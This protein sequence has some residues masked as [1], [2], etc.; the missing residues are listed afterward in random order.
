MRTNFSRY[1]SSA[2][3]SSILVAASYGGV[4]AQSLGEVPDDRS[5]GLEEIV[6]MAQKRSESLQ[7]VPVSV[8]ALSGDMV[9]RLNAVSLKDL[10]GTVP[11]VQITNF[12][13]LP[14]NAVFSIR[15]VGV[16]GV[17]PYV[18]N[19]VSIV[20]DEVPQYFSYGAL[21]DLFDVERVEV[22]KGP[23]GTLFGANTT[24]GV[25]NVITR[26]PTGEFGGKAEVSVGNYSRIDV[27]AAMDFPIAEDLAGKVAVLH[28]SRDG[29]FT[30]V[31]NGEDMGSRNVTAL[32]G[33][34]QWAPTGDFE[35]NL[36]TEYS[37]SRNGAP[38][39][40]NGA[41]AGDTAYVAP[42]TIVP[43]SRFPMYANPC[44]SDEV[45][46]KAPKKYYSANNSTPD[47]SDM[48][49]Y[50]AT[51]TL[52]WDDTA[53]GDIT[54][55]SGYRHFK[56]NEFTDQ[57]AT[58][59]FLL[60]THR[61]TEGWHFSQ[62]IRSAFDVT[63]R[64]S[65]LVGGFYM[66]THYDHFMNLRLPFAMTGYRSL[67]TQDQDNWSASVFAQTY[68]DLSDK[69]T[70]Q[71]GG[72]YTHEKTSMLAG[73][74]TFMNMNGDS[75]FSGD[76]PLGGFTAEGSKSWDQF[77]WKIGLDH[78][79]TENLFLY[80][81]YARGFKSGGFVGELI[82]PEDI[83]PYEP[84]KVDTIEAG[85]KGDW[86]NNRLR[87][88]LAVFY[89]KYKDMQVSQNYFFEDAN[90]VQVNGS[91]I[92]NAAK[93]TLKGAELEV[94]A[95]PVEGLT[96]TGA[97]A[98]LEAEYDRFDYTAATG[99]TLDL[100]GYRLQNAPKWS[101]SLAAS[102]EF[103]LGP[104]SM[105]LHTLYAYTGSKYLSA[106]VNP[107]RVYIQPTHYLSANI[108]W[109]PDNGSWSIGLWAT[110][111]LDKRYIQS[112]VHQPGVFDN[113]GYGAPREYGAMFKYNW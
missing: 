56:L 21:L 109:T 52:N 11:N 58:P 9:E 61:Q 7:T 98:Y 34:L 37:R 68:F 85:V 74:S 87:T 97:V 99:E 63:D 43:G 2:V 90:N 54:A 25:I 20:L 91:S 48:D 66:K 108:D 51:L 6:V 41:L 40:A 17:D 30:N 5:F 105:A 26:K 92:F 69:T 83:G 84:E 23:Q 64:I 29:F 75:V 102:Y 94:S 113:V 103:D 70:L 15:G 45:R 86:L 35:A 88:N 4:H 22:L 82:L 57:D 47:I 13:N 55:I 106:L 77:G 104:G 44:V 72:R 1:A 79:A 93:A 42:G 49:T 89:T 16:L 101:A 28:H 107:A 3:F 111:L 62:E 59:E 10:Q 53:L 14:N 67:N 96:L 38:V 31:V 65:A 8:A 100:T 80:T 46:C 36:I 110:N 60:D 71:L 39:H 81:Y 50:R 112:V 76:T 73:V 32:R 12:T 78:Q 18:G 33:Y 24:G 95:L 27:K 19:T